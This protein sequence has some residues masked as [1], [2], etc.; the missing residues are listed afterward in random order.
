MTNRPL[1]P[2]LGDDSRVR[3]NLIYKLGVVKIEDF[4]RSQ[5]SRGSILGNNP[6]RSEPLKCDYGKTFGQQRVPPVSSAT[7]WSL[8]NLFAKKAKV[9]EEREPTSLCSSPTETDI[10]DATSVTNSP[11]RRTRRLSF[12]E[13]VSVCLIPQRSEY[14]K[15]IK[16]LMWPTPDEFMRS[17][18]RNS[19]EF[20]AEGW[21]WRKTLEDDHMYR[22][23]ATNEL[24]HPVHVEHQTS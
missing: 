4:R 3:N 20:A 9:D 7:T 13:Q 5:N 19:I 15:R 2:V 11:P 10:S 23:V 18:Q 12:N 16:S 6:L 24:I 22:C 21:D 1:T 17:A 8:T 14:S